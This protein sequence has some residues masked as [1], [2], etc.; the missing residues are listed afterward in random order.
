MH[1]RKSIALPAISAAAV[2]SLSIGAFAA[3]DS[4]DALRQAAQEAAN[5]E[6]ENSKDVNFTSGALGLQKLNP[7]MSV[8]GDMVFRYSDF[9]GQKSDQEFDFR[10]LGL[11]LQAYLDPYTMFKAAIEFHQ[12]EDVELGEAY[13]TRFAILPNV[14]LTLGKFRQQFGV[15]NRWH[16]H[17]LDQTDYPLALREIFGDD[18]LNQTGASIEWTIPEFAGF[19]N[20]MIIQL[21]DGDNEQ[22]FG[23][24]SDNNL[25]VLAHYKIYRDLSDSTYAELGLSAIYG[26]NNE[27]QTDDGIVDDTLGTTVGG[28]DFT[29]LWEPT[30]RMRY[31]N[32]TWRSEAYI[33]NKDIVAPDGSG[34]D[35]I[36]AW[37]AYS[38]LESKVSRTFIIGL[39]GDWF[40]PDSKEYADYSITDGQ[41]AS[42]EPIAV[43]ADDPYRWQA[44]PYITWYQSPFVHFRLEYNLSSG[45]GTGPD[46][47]TVWLQ[48]IFAAGPHK[49]ERY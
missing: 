5:T 42:F 38:Y 11:H 29:M 20:S 43:K 33:L 23:Q 39:R 27:W 14:N 4:L 18:G 34:E 41:P 8:V 47:Q 1:I 25:S 15:V 7:E 13:M 31:R 44:T 36:N 17:G 6:E 9:D 28:V 48:C 26:Q 32:L 45:D 16:K 49:H 19:A 3:D 40:V 10:T 22:L 30:D 21:T 12:D 2:I 46:E 35:T 24:N 37:G